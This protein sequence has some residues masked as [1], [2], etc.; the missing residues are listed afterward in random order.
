MRDKTIVIVGAAIF[1]GIAAMSGDTAAVFVAVTGAVLFWQG[2][3]IEVKLN[4]ILDQAGLTVTK[5]DL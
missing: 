2:H 3:V 1:I 5:D 4:K